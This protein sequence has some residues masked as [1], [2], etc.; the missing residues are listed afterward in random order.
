MAIHARLPHLTS[1]QCDHRPGQQDVGTRLAPFQTELPG[2]H[3]SGVLDQSSLHRRYSA[4]ANIGATV[5]GDVT[6]LGPGIAVGG[7]LVAVGGG[8]IPSVG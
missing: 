8:V 2:F 1:N 3:P 6:L 4:K 5:G 7:A